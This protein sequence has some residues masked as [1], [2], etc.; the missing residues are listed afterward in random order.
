MANKSSALRQA[1]AAF[2]AL[3]ADACLVAATTRAPTPTPTPGSLF[4]LSVWL[5][6]LLRCCVALAVVSLVNLGELPAVPARFLALNS[7]LPAALE[8]LAAALGLGDPP[9]GA[10]MAEGVWRCWIMCAGASLAAASLWEVGVPD[11]PRGRGRKRQKRRVLFMRVLR[12]YRLDLALLL[13]GFCFLTMAAVCHL[14]N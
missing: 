7:A 8:S 6:A 10:S 1:F 3:V 11:S 13:G 9:C 2:W 14:H 5:F 12:M 4:W